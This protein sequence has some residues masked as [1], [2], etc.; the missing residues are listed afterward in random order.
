MGFLPGRGRSVWMRDWPLERK[1]VVRGDQEEG[2]RAARAAVEGR[3]RGW[4]E[5]WMTLG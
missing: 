4:K 2:S 3:G 1:R 5:R